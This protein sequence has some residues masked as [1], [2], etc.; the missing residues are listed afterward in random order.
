MLAYAWVCALCAHASQALAQDAPVPQNVM[1]ILDA[2]GSMWGRVQGKPKISIARDVVDNML[3]RWDERRRVGFMTYGH[4]RSGDC[5]DIEVLAPVGPLDVAALNARVQTLNPRGKT[6]ISEAVRTAARTLKFEEAR[7]TVILVSDGLETCDA[8][9]CALAADLEDAGID[10]TAHVVGF[11]VK[12]EDTT[13]LECLAERTGG[14]YFVADSADALSRALEA[15][16]DAS[17]PSVRYQFIAL[18]GPQGEA[19]G[20]NVRWRLARLGGGDLPLLDSDTPTPDVALAPGEYE[21][22]V[23]RLSDGANASV[24]F[25]AAGEDEQSVT[26]VLPALEQV[27]LDA[28]RSAPAG[29]QVAVLLRGNHLAGD[30]VEVVAADSAATPTPFSTA[31]VEAQSSV[32]ILMPPLPGRYQFHYRRPGRDEALAQ[33]AIDV[34]AVSAAINAVDWVS[35]GG[36]VNVTW[37]GPNYPG[38]YVSI[39]EVGADADTLGVTRETKEGRHLALV[40]PTQPGEY[41][42]RYV[43]R[44]GAIV[45]ARQPLSV[46]EVEA[47]VVTRANAPAGGAIEVMWVG[48]GREA[49]TIAIAEVG[50]SAGDAINVVSVANG[51]P[52]EVALPE[53]AGDFE[54]RYV[55]QPENRVLARRPISVLDVA[56]TL[57]VPERAVAG[58]A[59]P[60]G[61]SGPNLRDDYIGVAD[62]E[63]Q[64]IDPLYRRP[65]KQGSPLEI[66]TPDVP[67]RYEVRY[68]L[69]EDQRVL[70][71]VVIELTAP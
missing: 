7:S 49:D 31:V 52:V 35:A 39:V 17:T 25:V 18:D 42:V 15:A 55:M 58:S 36:E 41:E 50:A 54:V 64:T 57:D 13:S 62:P 14:Q 47:S 51:S 34:T 8:D 11:D 3:S 9:P 70:G 46:T 69:N 32:E 6:P 60:I 1:V 67:G 28:P 61:W 19:L 63:A 65:T 56:V 26:L 10:F 24:S 12:R 30:R 66:P 53:N 21:V 40:A 44:Q 71:V 20:G 16:L 43:M 33:Q 23:T 2:S 45:L 5:S 27:E 68:V 22:S 29:S 38:D 48:P 37:D 4:R 59:I